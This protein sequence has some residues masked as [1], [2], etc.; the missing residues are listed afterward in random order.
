MNTGLRLPLLLAQRAVFGGDAAPQMKLR[1]TGYL[2]YLLNQSKPNLISTSL[3]DRSG[4]IKDAKIRFKK[5]NQAPISTEDNCE[6]QALPAYFEQTLPSTS[7]SRTSVFFEFDIIK[8]FTEDALKLQTIGTPATSVIMEVMDTIRSNMGGLLSAINSDLMTA[9]VSAFGM[10]AVSGSNAARTINF[11]QN[12]ATNVLDSGVTR[13]LND[14]MFNE[15]MLDGAAIV[16]SGLINNYILQQKVKTADQAGVNTAAYG[17]PAFYYDPAA[18][19]IWGTNQFGLFAKDSVQLINI[20]RFRAPQAGRI[21]TSQLFTMEWP[22]IDSL[23]QPMASGFEFDVQ[24]REIDCPT[25]IDPGYGDP[26]SVGRGYVFDIMS[27]YAQVNIPDDA[28]G[29]A[30]PLFQNN[31]TYRYVATNT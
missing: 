31:G 9:Q 16:G 26:I 8:Q 18:A 13:L 2:N 20:C 5:R 17:L 22:L 3:D 11:A 15:T 30:D 28:Y 10:N 23:G 25:T 27:S 19:S 4:Y 14:A 21:G 7:F 29:A 6:I 1:P 24:V 12:A